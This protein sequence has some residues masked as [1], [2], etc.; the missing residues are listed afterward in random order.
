MF[1]AASFSRR[2]MLRGV[3]R[4]AAGL[5]IVRYGLG[6][7]PGPPPGA[8]HGDADPSTPDAG[9]TD[10]TDSQ[11]SVFAACLESGEKASRVQRDF[12]NGWALGVRGTP[13]FFVNGVELEKLVTLSALP[14]ASDFEAAFAANPV[15]TGTD[16]MLAVVEDDHVKGDPAAPN[17]IIEYSCFECHFCRRFFEESLPDVLTTLIDTGR[18]RFV[19]RHFPL[20]YHENAQPAAEASECAADQGRFFEYHDLLFQNQS[21]MTRPDLLRYADLLGLS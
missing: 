5:A 17:T 7:T 16:P 10:G 21:E 19:Y 11:R 1:Q 2:A 8:S 6:C 18:A 15:D 20:P 12:D 3:C 9:N 14:T 13:T 4:S